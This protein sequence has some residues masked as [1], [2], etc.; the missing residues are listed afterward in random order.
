MFAHE[1][2]AF[3][4][5][6]LKEQVPFDII[7]KET[8]DKDYDF[9]KN[10]KVLIFYG[11]EEIVQV[12]DELKSMFE[13]RFLEETGLSY[14]DP[15]AASL[16][17]SYRVK[18]LQKEYGSVDAFYLILK[19]FFKDYE[20][21]H[22]FVGRQKSDRY[23]VFPERKSAKGLDGKL[24]FVRNDKIQEVPPPPPDR[25][26]E[27]TAP[28]PQPKQTQPKNPK[29][30]QKPPVQPKKKSDK[31]KLEPAVSSSPPPPSNPE[32]NNKPLPPTHEHTPLWNKW[33]NDQDKDAKTNVKA[34]EEY[35]NKWGTPPPPKSPDKPS[36][37][38]RGKM[39]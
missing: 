23:V 16:L 19:L 6:C 18:I 1:R 25:R 12:V 29:P 36:G 27:K 33:D 3:L 8:G 9:E 31:Q 22:H 39:D 11:V 32:E 7:A 20:Q 37:K 21:M 17:V 2:L 35:E 13:K 28:K 15:K 24:H 38:I 14:N 30:K 34:I 5:K 4:A 26:K 10:I